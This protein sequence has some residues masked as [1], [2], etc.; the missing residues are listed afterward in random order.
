[1]ASS[2]PIEINTDAKRFDGR[3]FHVHCDP[4]ITADSLTFDFPSTGDIKF[5]TITPD[6]FIVISS[7]DL[8]ANVQKQLANHANG[9]YNAQSVTFQLGDAEGALGSEMISENLA[10][11]LCHVL[12]IVR[13]K[14]CETYRE[15]HSISMS[16][17]GHVNLT[18]TSA[19]LRLYPKLPEVRGDKEET[20]RKVRELAVKYGAIPGDD[21][22]VRDVSRLATTIK[23]NIF[24]FY[25]G[26]YYLNYRLVAPFRCKDK[27]EVLAEAK[28]VPRKRAPVV[29]KPRATPSAG[30]GGD[31]EGEG[32]SEVDATTSSTPSLKRK[33]EVPGAPKKR[34]K[35]LTASDSTIDPSDYANED[36]LALAY[37][38]SGL[39]LRQA[40]VKALKYFMEA[41]ASS[42]P[43]F[44]AVSRSLSAS[45]GAGDA[46]DS[47]DE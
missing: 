6:L 12:N 35:P 9:Q 46:D 20:A 16:N 31:A 39:P 13:N 38:K 19:G 2:A 7:P 44:T 4:M 30:A 26:A 29:R 33:A 34:A 14:A 1:M 21:G 32:T 36:D 18:P 25:K 10:S 23:V 41:E 3:V 15:V 43:T 8:L 47:D 5:G 24:G 11:R 42:T 22:N 37:V 27:P 17:P 45:A 28:K 40:T